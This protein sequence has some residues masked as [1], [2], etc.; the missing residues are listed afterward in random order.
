MVGR[1]PY[2]PGTLRALLTIPKSACF[3]VCRSCER[4]APLSAGSGSGSRE[5]L[6]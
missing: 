6:V 2:R 3:V 5:P 1:W 4:Y